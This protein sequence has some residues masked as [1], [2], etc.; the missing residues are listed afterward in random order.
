MKKYFLSDQ[1]NKI[2]EWNTSPRLQYFYELSDDAEKNSQEIHMHNNIVEVMIVNEGKGTCFINSKIY[3]VK[4]GDIII[5]NA[6][7]LHR[8]ILGSKTD[9]S[10]L[11]IKN[12]HIKGYKK[13][14]L[15]EKNDYPVITVKKI[16]KII[17]QSIEI[18]KFLLDNSLDDNISESAQCINKAILIVIFDSVKNNQL[19]VQQEK[20]NVGLRIKDYIDEHYLDEINLKS[21]AEAL[22][23]NVYYLSHTF[24]KFIGQTPVQY[25]SHR[26]VGEA[27]NLL[28]STNL[29]VTEIALQCGY[30]NSNYFQVVF[31]NIVGITP[32]KYRKNWQK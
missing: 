17:E 10:V 25:I 27:Q 8:I 29:T 3:N 16:F 11:G 12:L 19:V 15:T 9:I 18:L 1:K 14:C 5:I 30:N 2:F 28:I 31:N 13:D 7:S 22:N 6:G 20:Y 23:I 32:K 26:R 4:K 24:K 21:I